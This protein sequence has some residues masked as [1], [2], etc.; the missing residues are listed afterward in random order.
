[1]TEYVQAFNSA[2]A[3]SLSSYFNSPFLQVTSDG[4]KVHATRQEVTTFLDAVI[5]SAGLRSGMRSEV[6]SIESC[7]LV[8]NQILLIA[9]YNR[10]F[11][12][13]G[14][15]VRSFSYLLHK[16]R[17]NMQIMAMF[18]APSIVPKG[19]SDDAW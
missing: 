10:V 4:T 17:G 9:T 15:I 6:H 18:P 1:M 19:C 8:A 16:E 2:D 12:D 7:T 3:H 5:E 14:V 11:P 13:G